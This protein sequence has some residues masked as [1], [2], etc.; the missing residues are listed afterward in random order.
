MKV[1]LDHVFIFVSQGAPEAKRLID[2]GFREGSGRSH[3]GQGTSN[4]RFFFKNVYLELIWV[5]DVEEVRSQ[6]RTMLWERSLWKQNNFSPFG[7]G[8]RIISQDNETLSINT[9]DY[10]PPYIPK[11]TSIK[12]VDNKKRYCKEPMFFF[13]PSGISPDSSP[14]FS[15]DW[16][17]HK[18]NIGEIT[19][20]RVVSPN[21]ENL[22][23]A[24]K[25]F[26]NLGLISMK[27]GNIHLMELRFDKAKRDKFID[28]QPDLP[29]NLYW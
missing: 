28:L 17:K 5:R 10:K 14:E 11:E 12:I 18:D 21:A 29:L 4:R 6:S 7:M 16:L 27:K 25:W 22:S 26:Q 24:A 15:K 23:P 8:F 3:P 13:V 9:W 19:S 2:I 20:V 1:E